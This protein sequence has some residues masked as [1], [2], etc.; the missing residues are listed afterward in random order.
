MPPLAHGIGISAVDGG[1][2][3]PQLAHGI[4]GSGLQTP[5]IPN[6]V[7][8]GQKHA[9]N[10]CHIKRVQIG[11]IAFQQLPSPIAA[12]LAQNPGNVRVLCAG[13]GPLRA[14]LESAAANVPLQLLGLR[15]DIPELLAAADVF[16]FP[17]TGTEGLCLG[18][19]EAMAAGL[20]IVATAVSDLPN[21]VGDAMQL[22]PPGDVDALIAAC[23]GLLLHADAARALGS[24]AREAAETRFSD[25]A[26]VEAHMARYLA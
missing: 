1:Q 4:F 5:I 25:D 16:V 19:L 12:A 2:R 22:V 20:P 14:S 6:R 13:D 7:R 10:L 9:L 18:P 17:T 26:A 8:R 15:Q 23:R 24:R 21:I 11:A 3:G